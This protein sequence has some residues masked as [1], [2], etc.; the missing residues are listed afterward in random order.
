MQGKQRVWDFFAHTSIIVGTMFVAFFVIDRL[1]PEMEFLTSDLSRWLILVLAL[2]AIAVGLY[3]AI[4]LF[5][6]QKRLEEKRNEKQARLLYEQEF[7]TREQ[8]TR[9]SDGLGTGRWPDPPQV[10]SAPPPRDF[11]PEQTRFSEGRVREQP[12]R[13]APPGFERQFRDPRQG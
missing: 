10:R 8:F 5:Q 7:I 3:S 6:M 12:I 1:N 11:L 4:F 2:C 9:Q 13:P